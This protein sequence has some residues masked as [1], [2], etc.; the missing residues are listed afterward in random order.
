MADM[1]T[2]H[3]EGVITVKNISSSRRNPDFLDD[4]EQTGFFSRSKYVFK[5]NHKHLA[6]FS[7]FIDNVLFSRNEDYRKYS[8]DYLNVF[9]TFDLFQSRKGTRERMSCRI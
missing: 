8:Y 2:I 9:L 6:Q 4:Y 1:Q 3:Q 5:F 7:L